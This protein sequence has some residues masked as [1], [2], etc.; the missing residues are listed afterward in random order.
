MHIHEAVKKAM[1]ENGLIIRTS[2]REPRSDIYGAVRPTNSY[3]ACRLIVMKK[4]KADRACRCWNPTADDLMADDWAV[5][6]E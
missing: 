4:G 1:K 3:D 5:I 6:K 2:A